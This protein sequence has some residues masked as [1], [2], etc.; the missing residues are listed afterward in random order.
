MTPR[1]EKKNTATSFVHFG[2]VSAL[3]G[4]AWGMA[5]PGRGGENGRLLQSPARNKNKC[6][7]VLAVQQTFPVPS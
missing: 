1:T 6:L 7:L 4:V 5:M 3:L 2:G